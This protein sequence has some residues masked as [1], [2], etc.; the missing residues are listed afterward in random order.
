MH[1]WVALIVPGCVHVCLRFAVDVG[2]SGVCTFHI[3]ILMSVLVLNSCSELWN[4]LWS[5]L[6]Q[7][8]WIR[9]YI[10]ITFYYYYQGQTSTTTKNRE[11]VFQNKDLGD[12]EGTTARTWW[13]ITYWSTLRTSRHWGWQTWAPPWGRVALA[14][15]PWGWSWGSRT[16]NRARVFHPEWCVWFFSAALGRK[17]KMLYAG[18]GKK[19]KKS[20]NKD[21]VLT[22]LKFI[23]STQKSQNIKVSDKATGS[24]AYYMS[25][26]IHIYIYIQSEERKRGWEEEKE[27]EERERNRASERERER[28]REGERDGGRVG[29]RGA[30]KGDK[31]G[32]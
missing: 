8:S 4:E 24:M 17:V 18:C 31:G 25:P 14:T 7:S 19:Y 20:K 2:S 30:R 29:V 16:A 15:G 3:L 9:R 28:K 12:E 13:R 23:M 11:L 27:R 1:V 6:S 32:E 26:D 5:A 21:I 22:I 10:R